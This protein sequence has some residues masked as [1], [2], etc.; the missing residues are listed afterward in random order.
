MTENTIH[1]GLSNKE[2]NW[3]TKLKPKEGERSIGLTHSTSQC[4]DAS[5]V[6]RIYWFVLL[7]YL[8]LP[9]YQICSQAPTVVPGNMQ[10]ISYNVLFGESALLLPNINPRGRPI[11]L[12]IHHYFISVSILIGPVLLLSR[13]MFLAKLY[14]S[15]TLSQILLGETQA[16]TLTP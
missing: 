14:L 5:D 3:I 11:N 7:S 10:L 12:L 15:K 2:T 13:D 4:R 9:L 8:C 1:T 16:N 6:T